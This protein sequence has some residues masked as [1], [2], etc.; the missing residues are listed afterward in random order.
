M[1]DIN[2]FEEGFDDNLEVPHDEPA[3]EST[4]GGKLEEDDFGGDLNFGDDLSD[5]AEL[6]ADSLLDG[7]ETLPDFENEDGDAL[8][9][10]YAF[11]GP[12]DKKSPPWLLIGVGA[13]AVIAVLFLYVILPMLNK[14]KPVK[15]PQVRPPVTMPVSKDSSQTAAKPA[16]QQTPG[17][18]PAP[19]SQ[20]T[21]DVLSASTAVFENLSAG[22]QAGVVIINDTQYLV[23]YVSQ[24]PGV[25]EAMGKRIQTLLGATNFEVSPEEKH[26]TSGESHYWGVV[27]GTLPALKSHV[28]AGAANPY[29]SMTAFQDRIKA[30]ITQ[31][32]LTLEG[33]EKPAGMAVRPK[34]QISGHM[35]ITGEKEKVMAFIKALNRLEGTWGVSKLLLAPMSISDFSASKVK[36]GITF[37]V[38]I[39]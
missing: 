30:L 33:I 38:E 22:G 7:D 19:V 32:G 17:T 23:E 11:D 21:L 18:T 10:D 6:G 27:S 8:D 31:N 12:A 35:I 9:E 2:L 4:G 29:A 5:D 13:V 34:K 20:G 37:W 39:G 36:M 28:L 3:S 25:S 1:V 15:T 24:T 14:P 26:T 16:A